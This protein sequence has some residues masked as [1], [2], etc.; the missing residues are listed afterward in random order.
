MREDIQ[1]EVWKKWHKYARHACLMADTEE[2]R[3]F[4]HKMNHPGTNINDIIIIIIYLFIYLHIIK[5]EAVAS[6]IRIY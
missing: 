2:W 4:C 6:H 3:R 1:M 5:I